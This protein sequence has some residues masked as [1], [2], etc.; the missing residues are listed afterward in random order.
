MFAVSIGFALAELVVV[1]NLF[2]VLRLVVEGPGLIGAVAVT[3]GVIGALPAGH[4]FGVFPASG[5]GVADALV[6]HGAADPSGTALNGTTGGVHDIV[7]GDL[8]FL[9]FL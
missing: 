5:G 6:G 1:E 7:H 4:L 9:L 8:P 3:G 2:Q